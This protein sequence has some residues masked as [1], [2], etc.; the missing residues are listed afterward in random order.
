MVG[1][2]LLCTADRGHLEGTFVD[3][4]LRLIR[5][6]SRVGNHSVL[7]ASFAFSTGTLNGTWQRFDLSGG[8]TSGNWVGKKKVEDEAFDSY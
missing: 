5:R 7:K 3:G 2:Y 6:D 4:K 8:V 1:E